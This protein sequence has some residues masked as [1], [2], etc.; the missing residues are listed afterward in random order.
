MREAAGKGLNLGRQYLKPSVTACTPGAPTRPLLQLSVC[1]VRGTHWPHVVIKHR[2]CGQQDKAEM[3]N[4]S[5]RLL[6][7]SKQVSVLQQKGR[8]PG[9][10]EPKGG[11]QRA[12][13]TAKR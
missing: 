4:T 12:K 11:K 5:L 10:S 6:C 3:Q 8:E 9:G 2:A 7:G 13:G 1:T